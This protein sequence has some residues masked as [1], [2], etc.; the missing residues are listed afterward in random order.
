MDAAGA[1]RAV[2][3]LPRDQLLARPRR[4]P[5]DELIAQLDGVLDRA[6]TS[7]AAAICGVSFGGLVAATYA[8]IGRSG[9]RRW[10]SCPR[11]RPAWTPSPVQARYLAS[12][13]L[14]TPAFLASSPGR[15]WPEIAAAIDG[16]PSRLGFCVEH[17]ARIV[18]APIVPAQMAARMQLHA[19]R[20]LRADCARV[21]APTL[22]DHRRAG[23]RPGRAGGLDAAVRPPHSRA[24]NT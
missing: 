3:A 12:P 23:A 2:G 9:P 24:R 8:A 7:T 1:A 16:W 14:S 21:Q 4:R 17:L 10:S 19:G 18:A 5:F 15:M 13:W 11:R 6:R 22:V 20:R